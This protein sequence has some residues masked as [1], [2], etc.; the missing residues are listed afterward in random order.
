MDRTQL[1]AIV[2]AYIANNCDTKK[3][4]EKAVNSRVIDIE[5]I[6]SDDFT[7]VKAISYAVM[8]LLTEDI[9]PLSPETRKL[10]D[11]IYLCM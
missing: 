11:N 6:R 10:S 5:S 7:E 1:A 8:R 4:I 3:L 2:S 9:K